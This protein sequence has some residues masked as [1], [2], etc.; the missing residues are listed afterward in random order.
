MIN[1]GIVVLYILLIIYLYRWVMG[2]AEKPF[3]LVLEPFS[4]QID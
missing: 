1:I 3:Q 4:E 2:T